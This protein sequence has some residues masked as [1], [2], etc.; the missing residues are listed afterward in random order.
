MKKSFYTLLT[1]LMGLSAWADIPVGYYSNAIGKQNEELMTA[2]EGIIYT[3][4]LL[5]YDYMWTVS[6]T[7]LTLPTKA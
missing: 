7:H 2:L 4:T 3:H 6:Y 1:M 5:G